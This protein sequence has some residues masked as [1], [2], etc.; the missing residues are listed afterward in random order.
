MDVNSELAPSVVAVVVVHQPA[1]GFEDVLAGLA[2]Q[3]YPNLK[4]LFLIAGDAGDLPA[5]ISA[6]L[7]DGFVRA[8]AGNPGFGPVA[9]EVLRLVEGDNGFFMLMHDDVALEPGA[10]RLLVEELYRSNAGIVG[11]KFVRWDEPGVLQH[12]GLGVDRFGEIDPLVEPGEADQ[13]QHDAVRDVFAL[14]SACLLVRADL[15]RALGGFD[16]ATTF[17]GDDVDLC[18]RAHLGGAR[19]VVVPAARARHREMLTVR[20]PDLPH[21]VLA[22]RHRVRSVATLTGGL[23]LPVLLL[24]MLLLCVLEMVVG[25]FTGRLGEAFASLRATLG[26]IPRV[27]TVIRRRREVSRLREVPYREVAGLQ[28]RGSARLASYL[29]TREQQHMAVDHS[30]VGARRFTRNTGGQIAAWTSIVVL[31]VIGSRQFILHGVPDVGELSRFPN[32]AR[33]L[34]GDYWSGWWG[35]GLGRTVATP[36]GIGL[37]G[38]AGLVSLGHLGLLHTLAVLAWL[39]FGYYGAWRLMSIFPSSR[40]RIIGLVA[41]AAVPLPYNA[42]AAGRWGVVAAYG[43]LPWVV[44]LMRGIARIEPALTARADADVADAFSAVDVREQLRKLAQLALL[45]AVVSAF[46]PTFAG[47]V[48]IVGLGL[49]IATLVARSAFRAALTLFLSGIIAGVVGLLINLPWLSTLFGAGGWDSFV[50]APAA[51]TGDLSLSRTLRF[52]VGPDKLGA[53]AIALWLPV[54]A[55]PLLARGWRLT[56]SARA[57]VLAVA[58]LALAVVGQRDLLPFRLPETG[59]LLAPAAVGLALA[60]A[61]AAAAFEQDVQGG[62]FG[63]RQPLGV[64]CG[65]ALVLGAIPAVAATPNG[66]WSTPTSALLQPSDQFTADPAAGDSRTLYIGD[67]RVMPVNGWRLDPARQTGVSYAVVDDGPLDIA[68]HWPGAPS[69]TE[70]ALRDVLGLMSSNA[71]ARIGRLL[72]PF[73]IRYIVVPLVNGIDSTTD[74]PL[75]SPTGLLTSLTTQLDLKRLYTPPNYIAF[76]NSAWIPTRSTLSPSAALDSNEAGAQAL[77]S[78][79]FSGSTAALVGMPDRGPATG[80]VSAGVLYVAI[81]FD[82][83]WQLEVDGARIA[84][85][86]AFGSTLAF[87]VPKAGQGT[88]RY[89]TDTSRHLAVI[90]QLL[91]WLALALLASRVR[92]S[93]LRRRRRLLVDDDGPVLRLGDRV[94]A[95]APVLFPANLGPASVAPFEID[96]PVAAMP[97]D[98]IAAEPVA[99]PVQA[100]PSAEPVLADPVQADE[101][102]PTDADTVILTGTAPPAEV[103]RPEQTEQTEEPS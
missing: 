49:A 43:A 25:L 30:A 64:L 16:V 73:S 76:E 75:A 7:P 54:L 71:T 56:W 65:A 80:P 96:L 77:A 44:H 92:W 53:L 17:Y 90:V 63:W 97:D 57:G 61:C 101:V 88:L 15:F 59:L 103:V 67:T 32:S 40:A 20:R 2:A 66:H 6:A 68:E 47:I 4:T 11:P 91:A 74:K 13:E 93:W 62:S 48:V 22:A 87:D 26:L 85:R 41:F 35:H 82:P 58:A 52:A 94:D 99:E 33:T 19:V 89:V 81:P 8:V 23:R 29:R 70:V 38:L 5:T 86:V 21:R 46:V 100:E 9:N 14:P 45:T 36:T 28:I 78:G 3:D 84:P 98:A 72:A 51:T 34:L 18:W 60:A 12:V 1:I 102:V 50:G 55:A 27:G 39:P 79:D 83:H 31:A 69:S 24:Q 42:L 10:V 37:I 95:P